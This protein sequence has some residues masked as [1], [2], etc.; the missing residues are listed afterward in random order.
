M[1]E[2]NAINLDGKEYIIIKEIPYNNVIYTYL[3]EDVNNQEFC[4][5]KVIK[6]ND[7]DVLVRLDNENEFNMALNLYNQMKNS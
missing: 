5:R 1:E 4:I 6:E 3:V 7:K 2:Y